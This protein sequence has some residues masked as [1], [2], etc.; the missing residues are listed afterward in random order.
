MQQARDG[1]LSSLSDSERET[2]KRRLLVVGS[3]GPYGAFLADGSEYRGDYSLSSAEF[4]TFHH[5]RIE[6]L[7]S[8]GVDV[9]ACETMPSLPE[10]KAL[11]ELLRADFPGTEAWFSFTLKDEGRISDGTPLEDV[12]E[13]LEDVEQVV[14]VGVN[15]VSDEMAL[16]ALKRLKQLTK[17][18]LIVYP[19]SG[20]QWN[21]KSRDWYGE[22]NEGSHLAKRTKEMWKAGARIIGG[23]CRTTPVDIRTIAETLENIGE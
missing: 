2:K 1:Y 18:P 16:A 13:L 5:G 22:R 9:L 10:V 14:A 15:C 12:V 21:A 11:V 23:C 3:V 20:E 4:K 19:N 17:K 7:F 8:A 6:A